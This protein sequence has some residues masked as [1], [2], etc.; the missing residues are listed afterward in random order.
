M[1]RFV[2]HCCRRVSLFMFVVDVVVVRILMCCVFVAFVPYVS[3]CLCF[4][5]LRAAFACCGV[6]FVL[7]FRC[8]CFVVAVFSPFA[9]LGLLMLFCLL[10]CG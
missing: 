4:W 9:C 3:V 10:R 1:V 7:L 6:L 8:C 2:L 5:G